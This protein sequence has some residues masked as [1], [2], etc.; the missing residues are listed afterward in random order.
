MFQSTRPHRARHKS[1]ALSVWIVCFNPRAHTG[2][3]H[4]TTSFS[5]PISLFQ[6]TRPHRARLASLSIFSVLSL[7]QS[8]RPHRARRNRQGKTQTIKRFNPRAHT[9]R[10][11]TFA[12]GW[13]TSWTFQSTRP[14]RARLADVLRPFR[15]A[16]VSIHA[17]TQGA[18]P[19][20]CIRDL[21]ML[22]FQSTRPHR[23]RQHRSTLLLQICCFNPRAHTGRDKQLTNKRLHRLC[24]N[25]RAHTGRDLQDNQSLQCLGCFNPRA[26]TGRDLECTTKTISMS[27]FQ[28]TRPHRARLR[29]YVCHENE[30]PFQSTRPHRARPCGRLQS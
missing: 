17:P 24:F 20:S 23:A 27:E 19:T 14:H 2:R 4:N 13:P 30:I 6:S 9:G 10:D 1:Y 25:P 11:M 29:K 15:V 8:T 22:L 7:F 18:T 3:D 21:C 5:I 28:S 16:I 12:V 26:H